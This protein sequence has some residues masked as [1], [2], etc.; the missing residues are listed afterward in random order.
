MRRGNH[1]DK[2]PGQC[3]PDGIAV[4]V[5][6]I[7]PRFGTSPE[8]DCETMILAI[9]PRRAGHLRSRQRSR[10]DHAHGLLLPD[11]PGAAAACWSAIAL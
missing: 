5:Q 3:D 4:L 11:A 8:V 2:L 7:Q 6:N 9:K 1:G 10:V